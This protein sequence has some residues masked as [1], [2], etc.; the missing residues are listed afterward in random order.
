MESLRSGD[1]AGGA[2]TAG[3]IVSRSRRVP[4]TSVGA[5]F[6]LYEPP[7]A[8][9][10]SP[11]EPTIAGC[12][13][14]VTL[15]ASGAERVG[16]LSSAAEAVFDD[17]DHDGPAPSRPRFIG[18]FSFHHEHDAVPPWDGF[19]AGWFVLPHVQLVHTDDD[20]WLTVSQHGTDVSAVAVERKLD[21]VCDSLA[22]A[23]PSRPRPPAGVESRSYATSREAWQDQVTTVL[24]R[25]EAGALSK[26]VLAQA[27]SVTPEATVSPL[28]V[29]EHLTAVYPDCYRFILEPTTEAAFL[30]ATPERLVSLTDRRLETEA[31]AGST[32]RG[33]TSAE[34]DWLESELLA[35]EKDRHEHD[36]VVETICDRLEPFSTAVEIGE[37]YVRQ[38][39]TVQHLQTPITAT[40]SDD[41]HVFE[42]I[43]AL[44]PTPAVGGLPP[45]EAY[46]AIRDAERFDRGWYAA[47]VGWIDAD[48]NGTFAIAIRSA[49]VGR[50]SVRLF[51]GA[52]IVANSVPE[53][54][55][56]ELQLKYRPILDA[57][58]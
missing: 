58:E 39:A 2:D 5:L 50:S 25:I 21:S 35:S 13:A 32:G 4:E 23:E 51:A 3:S 14:A 26:V 18:G 8:L 33:D 6:E 34:D 7:R 28:A 44:H 17:L 36:L 9:L 52:G 54:E 38:L 41:Y 15:H 19:P 1:V 48:G 53:R 31:I 47:P 24:D 16:S 55:W 42:L 10:R 11:D 57:L 56:D 49:V 45:A 27:L 43:E 46:A 37:L 40:L 29:L 20:Y 22:G 12:G 30:G